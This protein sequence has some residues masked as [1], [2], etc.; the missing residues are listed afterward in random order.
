M[1]LIVLVMT[2]CIVR[3]G[4]PVQRRGY[5]PAPAEHGKHKKPKKPNKHD[6]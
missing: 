4:R 6:D 3:S 2:A 1:L 5:A